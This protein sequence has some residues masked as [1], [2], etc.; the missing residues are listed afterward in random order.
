MPDK[1]FKGLFKA[2]T[3]Q[4]AIYGKLPTFGSLG[5]AFGHNAD[6]LG[7][8]VRMKQADQ[9][10]RDNVLDQLEAFVKRCLF[11]EKFDKVTEVY[12]TGQ[13]HAA[14]ELDM[15]YAKLLTNYSIRKKNYALVFKG[16]ENRF[17]LRQQLETGQE[18]LLKASFGI[19][20]LNHYTYGGVEMGGLCGILGRSGTGKS[21]FLKHIAITNARLGLNVAHIQAEDTLAKCMV[22]YDAGW[23]GQLKNDLETGRVSDSVLEEARETIKRLQGEIMVH[24][25]EQFDTAKL[26]DVRMH[27]MEMEKVLA[28][29]PDVPHEKAKMHVGIIDYLELFD[30]ADGKTYK[31]AEERFRREATANQIKNMAI[32]FEM[33]MFLGT[34]A[35]DVPRDKWNRSDFVMDRSNVAECKGLAR[36]MN[37]FLTLNQTEEEYAAQIMRVFGD[38]FRD[39]E[40]NK[41]CEFVQARE[42]GRFYSHERTMQTYPALA[43]FN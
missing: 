4:Y 40:A 3:D 29:D 8:I 7:L 34:Q 10:D 14:Y 31:P 25:F 12:N 43:R 42:R 37:Y 5:Q 26:S 20:E 30:P 36:P 1:R 16:F 6:V 17:L 23:T 39:H 15:E 32:E 35:S 38:K 33:A 27:M 24:A 19:P 11:L 22:A 41:L 2:I 9:P 13:H 21:T 18:T 28:S